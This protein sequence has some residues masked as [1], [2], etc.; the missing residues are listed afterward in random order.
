MSYSFRNDIDKIEWAGKNIFS[1]FAQKQNIWNPKFWKMLY[2]ILRFN[3]MGRLQSYSGGSGVSTLGDF[4]EKFKFS[5]EF[6]DWYLLPM[7]GA[8]WSCSAKKIR[9]YPLEAF[10]SF[11]NN[12]GL[13]K[14]FNR[15]Q[16]LTVKGGS[17][18]YVKKIVASL[19]DKRIS[20]KVERINRTGDKLKIWDDQGRCNSFSLVILACHADEILKMLEDSTQL[21][22]N[23]L[24]NFQFTSNKAILHTNEDYL[25]KSRIAHS[26]WNYILNSNSDDS[27][28]VTVSYLLNLLQPLPTERKIILTLNP[29]QKISDR[30]ILDEFQ[31]SHPLLDLKAVK[32]QG[33]LQQIQGINKTFFVGAWTGNGF[34]ES[35]LN[36]A[37]DISRS[38]DV[39]LPW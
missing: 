28:K 21:E 25:P 27:E 5:R 8:I 15:P 14:N 3:R 39:R 9:N 34:H 2:D 18:Q 26:A 22:Q 38:I 11:F 4:L 24:G 7:A 23:I 30:Y 29:K 33:K 32:A 35:G 17:R 16:W 19:R 31:Y 6:Q 10:C 20:T 12:H 36:S 37:I 13:L 1:L